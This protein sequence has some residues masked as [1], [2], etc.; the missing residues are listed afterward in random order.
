MCS[1]RL[2]P[3]RPDVALLD[4]EM[5]GLDG[6]AAAAELARELPQTRTPANE[7]VKRLAER[8]R[9]FSAAADFQQR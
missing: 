7:D 2:A 4:I 6:I 5:P 9:G 1:P 3:A 8:G